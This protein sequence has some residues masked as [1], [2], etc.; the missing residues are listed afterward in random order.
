M[1]RIVNF[2][3][4][5]RKLL[6]IRNIIIKTSVFACHVE[7]LG[8]IVITRTSIYIY[9]YFDDDEFNFSDNNYIMNLKNNIKLWILVV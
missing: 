3:D 5:S 7:L 1:I 9:I 2:E 4:T 8:L 6:K